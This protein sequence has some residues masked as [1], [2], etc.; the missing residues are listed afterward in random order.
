MNGHLNTEGQE[1]KTG[2]VKW[3][4]LL[5]EENEEDEGG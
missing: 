1:L 3:R 5:G 2:H 4:A